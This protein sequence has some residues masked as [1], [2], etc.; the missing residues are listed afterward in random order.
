MSAAQAKFAEIVNEAKRTDVVQ[1]AI[2]GQASE[3]FV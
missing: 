1:K 2:E 3:A